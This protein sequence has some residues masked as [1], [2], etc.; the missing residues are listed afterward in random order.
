MIVQK[1]GGTSLADAER[2]AAAA[3][4]TAARAKEGVLVVA[5]ALAGATDTLLEIGRCAAAGHLVCAREKLELLFARHHRVATVFGI[6]A[7]QLFAEEERLWRLC[8]GICAE[9]NSSPA[10]RD[11]FAATG[12][13]LSSQIFTQALHRAGVCAAWVDPRQVVATD[14]AFG[15]AVPDE[16]R[17]GWL[18]RTKVVPLVAWGRV[19]V[20]GGF[21]GRAPNGRTT[22]L[23]RGGSDY[24]AALLGA[25]LPASLIEIWTD[26]DGVFDADPN[27]FP[28]AKLLPELSYI[29]ARRMAD[30]GAKV[31]HPKTMEPAER[32]GVPIHVRNSFRPEAPG[33]RITVPRESGRSSWRRSTTRPPGESRRRAVRAPATAAR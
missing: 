2:I 30:A 8:A 26:V 22:T 31:L 16:A 18:V 19:V 6:E 28:G 15:S 29:E 5:S 7:R 24:T 20:T 17:I 1:F 32:A 12:E 25:A 27:H 14:G 10:S 23:G 21:V 3:R 9:E 13:L 33:T 11:E 4:I